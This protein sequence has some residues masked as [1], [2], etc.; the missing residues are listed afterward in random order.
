MSSVSGSPDLPQ[1]L[2]ATERP[3]LATARRAGTWFCSG[4]AQVMAG[5]QDGV[6]AGGSGL[7]DTRALAG[8][9]IPAWLSL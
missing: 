2:I 8:R 4:A 6:L 7:S 9:V 3:G 1:L 5:L